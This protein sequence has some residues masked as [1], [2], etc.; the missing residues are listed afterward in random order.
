MS[1]LD[2]I[3]PG[4]LLRCLTEGAD[5]IDVDFEVARL[6]RRSVLRMIE[7]GQPGGGE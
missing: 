6:A 1:L 5:E 2:A 3:T 7:I 4:A